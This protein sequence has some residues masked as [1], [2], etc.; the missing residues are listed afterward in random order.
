M[1]CMAATA[2]SCQST[3]L[4]VSETNR[5]TK[6]KIIMLK[7]KKKTKTKNSYLPRALA[8]NTCDD[9]K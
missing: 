2:L 8:K 7:N 3:D 5:L 9:L 1:I 4:V 6:K